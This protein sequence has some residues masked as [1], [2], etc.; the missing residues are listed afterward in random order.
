MNN[1]TQAE[2]DVGYGALV[3][4]VQLKLCTCPLH[5]HRWHVIR[6]CCSGSSLQIHTSRRLPVSIREFWAQ[7]SG[8]GYICA[9][10][11]W[12]SRTL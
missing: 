11:T 7:G 2:S 1:G 8:L 5:R 3:V 10:A 9:H 12:G 4:R 6:K